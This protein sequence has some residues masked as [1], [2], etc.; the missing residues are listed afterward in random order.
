MA[1]FRLD[2]TADHYGPHWLNSGLD[3]LTWRAAATVPDRFAF[4]KLH[5]T[6]AT[7]VDQRH[8]EPPRP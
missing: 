1:C 5:G 3:F 6:A 8:G 4:L 2:S 7:W